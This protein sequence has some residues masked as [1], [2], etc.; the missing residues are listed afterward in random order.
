MKAVI[1]AGGEGVRLRPL[2]CDMPKPMAKVGNRPVLGYILDLLKKNGVRDCAL[3]LMYR[4]QAIRDYCA[5]HAPAGMD[6]RFF[7]EREPLGTAG[8]VKNCGDFLDDETL[9][10]SGDAM[11]DFDLRAAV[12]FHRKNGADATLLLYR[13]EKP[14][15]YGVTLTDERG[16]ITRFIEKPSWD[17]VYADTVNTGVYILSPSVIRMIDKTPC[18]F[19]RDV[20]PRM[21]EA[22]MALYG[23]VCEG[24][25]CDIG[26]ASSYLGCN[27]HLLDGRI[28]VELP[29]LRPR[30]PGAKVIPPVIIGSGVTVCPGAVVG[31]YAVIGDRCRIGARAN[32]R[33]SVF[34]D[35]VEAGEG[36]VAHGAVVCDG[37]VL[38]AGVLLEQGV[39]VGANCR[40]GENA[41]IRRDVKIWPGKTVVGKT[42]LGISQT[43]G[44]AATGLFG[45]GGID[46]D[47]TEDINPVFAARLGVAAAQQYSGAIAVAADSAAA[48]MLADAC[49]AAIRS[50][51]ADCVRLRGCPVNLLRFYAAEEGTTCACGM[52]FSVRGNRAHI[53][54]YERDGFP[55]EH[56]AER[57]LQNS[58]F[59][60]EFR[61]ASAE[62]IGALRDGPEDLRRRY[63]DAL[64]GLC[65]DLAGLRFQVRAA[66]TAQGGLL[67]GSLRERGG[68][69]APGG[70]EIRLSDGGERFSIS[71]NGREYEY[72]TLILLVAERT[73]Q[74]GARPVYLPSGAPDLPLR[75][76]SIAVVTDDGDDPALFRRGYREM[77]YIFDNIMAA[78]R[79]ADICRGGGLS[80]AVR[81][82]PPFSVV[83]DE[84][85]ARAGRAYVMRLLGRLRENPIRLGKGVTFVGSRGEVTIVPQRKKEAFSVRAQALDAEAAN[86]LWEDFRGKIE[87]IQR[88]LDKK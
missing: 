22:G 87:K 20:F 67:T 57:N 11:C 66:D 44:T 33:N 42:A 4:P 28:A 9:V 8:S 81:A 64:A 46:G 14:L 13:V 6:L 32:I 26:S 41:A 24:Y 58:F 69:C 50:M 71:E 37:T 63:I 40:I 56:A 1:M 79:C 52:H 65:G 7:E 88:E 84:V 34:G 53:R 21:L 16:R 85:D 2:T 70:W 77:P 59:R 76:R 43:S 82:L 48:D 72:E 60:D 25:W 36:T 80:E 3:T 27:F 73:A 54:I 61:P 75:S 83:T 17:R 47:I 62:Q 39:V 5:A 45:D 38:Q 15:E 31:P 29:P 19:G 74:G 55:P 10:I 51:G 68:V 18:D 49:A 23:F 86:E 78:V 12:D 30:I 35:G